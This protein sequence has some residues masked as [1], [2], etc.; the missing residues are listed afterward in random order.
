MDRNKPT[1]DG[2]TL[3]KRPIDGTAQPQQYAPDVIL[4]PFLYC[5]NNDVLRNKQGKS[6]YYLFYLVGRTYLKCHLRK[7]GSTK[8]I[9]GYGPQIHRKITFECIVAVAT[10]HRCI[11]AGHCRLDDRL[12]VDDRPLRAYTAENCDDRGL[13]WR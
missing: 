5:L 13:R 8:R 4:F 10:P 11:G 7:Y 6:Q 9:D 3:R 1:S 12:F 2:Q